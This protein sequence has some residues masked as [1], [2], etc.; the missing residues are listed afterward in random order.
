MRLR[1]LGPLLASLAVTPAHAGGINLSWND[2]GTFGQ[3]L[4][5]FACNA[6]TGAHRLVASF[7]APFPLTQ[8]VGAEVTVDA[9]FDQATVPSW[10]S[11]QSPGE[12]RA[13]ALSSNAYFVGGPNSC[14]DPWNGAA[15]SGAFGQAVAPP[16]N[17]IRLRAV[18]AV[19]TSSAATVD[20]VTEHYALEILI[21]HQ[22]TVG[23]GACAGC[24]VAGC[25]MLTDIK[26][27]QPLGVGDYT[28]AQPL[29][30]TV[31]GW[32]CPA[33]PGAPGPQCFACPVPS[34]DRSWGTI[35]GLYR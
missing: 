13:G 29:S 18:A 24:A 25:L 8:L 4:E 35:K 15:T 14:A 28:L 23:S 32:Q 2:C 3:S 19:P 7:V 34:K 26:L 12:C 31:V 5:T 20:D 17:R 1:Y 9:I 27:V 33:F 6:N 10:W 21:T 22:K 30:N 16:A 11:F